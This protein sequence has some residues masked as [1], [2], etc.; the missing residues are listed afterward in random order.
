MAIIP[1]ILGG[2]QDLTYANYRAYESLGRVINILAI[3]PMF[4]LGTT[5]Q[6]LDSRSYLNK[7][8]LHQPNFLFNYT[9]L[10]YQTYFVDPGSV[11]LMKNLYFD[12]YRLGTSEHN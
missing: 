8:I 4:D 5:E 7:I 11:G 6:E 2:S 12:I 1:V 3:D 10:G 9:N